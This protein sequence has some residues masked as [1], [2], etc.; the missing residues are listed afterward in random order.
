MTG[1]K[2]TWQPLI[3]KNLSLAIRDSTE[4]TVKHRYIAVGTYRLVHGLLLYL[5]LIIFI[6]YIIF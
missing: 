5:L 2:K 3:D 6:I 4:P 1:K